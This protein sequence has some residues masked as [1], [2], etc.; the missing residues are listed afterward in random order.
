[1]QKVHQENTAFILRRGGKQRDREK[2][3]ERGLSQDPG[4]HEDKKHGKLKYGE[5]G[6]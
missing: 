5:G 4:A 6:L 3:R 1:M 2:E